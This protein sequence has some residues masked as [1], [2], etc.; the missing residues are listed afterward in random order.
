MYE[1]GLLTKSSVANSQEPVEANDATLNRIESNLATDKLYMPDEDLPPSMLWSPLKQNMTRSRC[2]YLIIGYRDHHGVLFKAV[3]PM[4]GHEDAF[5]A[6]YG[7][8]SIERLKNACE[9]HKRR[10]VQP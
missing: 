5:N 4:S 2:G 1:L 8:E 6:G 10:S 7:V 3:P 9:N